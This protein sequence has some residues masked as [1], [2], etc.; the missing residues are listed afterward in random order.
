[1]P[2]GEA[3]R[4]SET[5]SNPWCGFI[6]EIGSYE[7]RSSGG[8]SGSDEDVC[9]VVNFRGSRLISAGVSDSRT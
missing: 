8:G 5:R 2:A 1:M 9:M 7:G 4:G 3:S 6:G